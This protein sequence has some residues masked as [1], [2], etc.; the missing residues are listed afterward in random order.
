MNR[1]GAAADGEEVNGKM[2]PGLGFVGLR[3]LLFQI[4]ILMGPI[5][6]TYLFDFGPGLDKILLMERLRLVPHRL[7]CSD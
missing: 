6:T 7:L 4:K 5:A 3:L 2:Q 1:R